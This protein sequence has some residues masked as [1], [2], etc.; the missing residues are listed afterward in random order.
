MDKLPF[1]VERQ[2]A[3]VHTVKIQTPSTKGFEQWFLCRSDAHHDSAKC[4]RKLEKKHLDQA[5]ER[6]AG[7]L[8][9]GDTFDVMQSPADKRQSK[10]D[11]RPEHK[12]P[13]YF[14]AVVETASEEYLPY[15]RNWILFGEGNHESAVKA[16][17]GIDL[18]SNLTMLLNYK[19]K[20]NVQVGGYA[21]YVRFQFLRGSA[22]ITS[23]IAKYHH[24]SGGGGPVTGGIIQAQRLSNF[25]T[26]ADYVFQGHYH[27]S[28]H[29]VFMKEEL[30]QHGVIYRPQYHLCAGGYKNDYHDGVGGWS[31]E[32]GHPPK[33]R[34]AVWLRF[35]FEGNELKEEISLA[36]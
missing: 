23:R 8:D 5:L 18:L 28:W 29:R 21:G 24:G 17:M 26:N 1:T 11:L 27:E 32:R 33:P 20:A 13:D 4:D 36:T 35:Y 31:V 16:K 15:A 9:W 25:V 10:G 19:A 3:N 34:G 12:V 2:S 14:N 22:R 30:G 6:G 7:I